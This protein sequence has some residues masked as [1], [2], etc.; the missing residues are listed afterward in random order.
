[1]PVSTAKQRLRDRLRMQR[2]ALPY[3]DVVE[4][5]RRISRVFGASAIF[6]D[7][8]QVILYSPTENEV[9]TEAIWQHARQEGK[10]VYY[11]R[12]TTDRQEIEFVLRSEGKPLVPGAFDIPV[13]QGDELL[14]GVT[15]TDVVVTPAVAFDSA[16]HRLGRGRGYYDRAFR[17]V[18]AGALRVGVAYAFQIIDEVPA[19]I[20][21]E[22]VDYVV[23]EAGCLEC[24]PQ[25]L[26]RRS[27][28]Q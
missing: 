6:R 9:D 18:L 20:R 14:A 23:T 10:R 8:R 1:M 28:R 7:A 15:A 12:L 16:G 24:T 21:D 22:R 19:D 4:R 27:N 2:R 17:S 13:P 11:P 26:P 5:S 25:S 3:A